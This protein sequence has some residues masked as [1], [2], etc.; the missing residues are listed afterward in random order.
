MSSCILQPRV[1][2]VLEVVLEVVPVLLDL[3]P[4]QQAVALPVSVSKQSRIKAKHIEL[5]R[6]HREDPAEPTQTIA[7][8][9]KICD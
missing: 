4:D 8:Y 2:V 6:A 9:S 1:E 5:K 3:L 7:Q